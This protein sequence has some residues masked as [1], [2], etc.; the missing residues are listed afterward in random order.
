M[1][2][3]KNNRYELDQI[4]LWAAKNSVEF[5]TD[6]GQSDF[7]I[8]NTCTVTHVA[9]KKSRQLIRKTKNR[10]KKLK[11]IVFG[12]GARMQKEEFEKIDE[13]DYLLPDLP[14]V[15]EFLSSYRRTNVC[16]LSEGGVSPTAGMNKRSRALVQIQDG[17]DNFCTYCITVLARG[18]SQNRSVDEI[19]DEVNHHI[20][21]GFN[22]VVLTGINIGAYGC[23]KTTKP[24]ESKLA[25]LLHTILDKTTIKRVRLTS[26]GP[27]YFFKHSE[28][29]LQPSAFRFNNL[30]FE[31]LKNPRI[32][33]HIHL[34]IQSG[35]DDV[36]EKM[37]RN[38]SVKQMDAVIERLKKD[39]PGIAITSD[40]IVGFPDETDENFKETVEF[41][42]RNKLAKVHVFP[43]SIR[44]GTAAA[45]M[46]QIPD[47]IK[48]K[49]VKDLQL[50]AEGQ[51]KEFIE[52]QI[53]KK[54]SVLW[55][56]ESG[57]LRRNAPA[58]GLW[59]GLTD[60]YIRVRKKGDYAEKSVTDEVLTEGICYYLSSPI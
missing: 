41:V 8:I 48:K 9:D 31:I 1:T 49:R 60:N 32:C 7:C 43:Y 25:E 23:S 22:E 10:N 29:N 26:M 30:L 28:V 27:E 35:S 55:E 59:E 46:K 11:M 21:N 33:R 13:I 54:V 37:R 39:I 52:S 40:I 5:V 12:C 14:A 56:K 53:G 3:C 50:I 44:E 16:P 34:A 45:T 57:A 58:L 2:G 36:L 51:R 6:E 47:A 20:K 17:C 18:R 15:L 4:I 38:Y 42:K 19:I 24:E